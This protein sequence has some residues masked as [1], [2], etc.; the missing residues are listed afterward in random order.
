MLVNRGVLK[1]APQREVDNLLVKACYADHFELVT[2]LLNAGANPMCSVGTETGITLFSTPMY[3]YNMGET[4]DRCSGSRHLCSDRN[5]AE[6][7]TFSSHS[8]VLATTM[9]RNKQLM[10]NVHTNCNPR[11]THWKQLSPA[12]LRLL[13]HHLLRVLEPITPPLLKG[14][15][16]VQ[17]R[18]VRRSKSL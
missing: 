10:Q 6:T 5:K 9:T 1:H 2:E 13:F 7:C 16:A 18:H 14:Q 3:S 8:Q 11:R 17:R 4:S 12:M 15:S